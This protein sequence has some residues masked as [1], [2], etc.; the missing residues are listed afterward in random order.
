MG[1]F[2]CFILSGDACAIVNLKEGNFGDN[3]GD[4]GSDIEVGIMVGTMVEQWW[5]NMEGNCG[6]NNYIPK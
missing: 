6:T 5:Y 4:Y 2:H 1:N 3:S